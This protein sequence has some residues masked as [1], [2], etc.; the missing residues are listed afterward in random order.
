AEVAPKTFAVQHAERAAMAVSGLL[1]F[2]TRFAPFRI[3]TRGF[4]GLANVVL[5]GRGLR[6]GPFVTEAEILTMAD[7][8][9]QE[10]PIET[11]ARYLS[12]SLSEFCDTVVRALM[13]PRPYMV[14]VEAEA[15]V[16]E[17]IRVAIAACKSR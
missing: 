12:H 17:A 2:V 1:T 16:D 3:L 10:A 14:A 6:G 9:A 11:E 15:T 4:I 8:A 5:P 13:V 7:V